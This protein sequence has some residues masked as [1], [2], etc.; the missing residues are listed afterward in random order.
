MR[1]NYYGV[2]SD[3]YTVRTDYYI[4]RTD[5]SC[6]QISISYARIIC[7]FCHEMAHIVG[8]LYSLVL[9]EQSSVMSLAQDRCNYNRP[10]VSGHHY[11]KQA[12][13]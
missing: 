6:A 2:R 9:I 8:L 10:F 12:P 7:W 13:A 4:V 3:Y 11:N 1:M 5:L